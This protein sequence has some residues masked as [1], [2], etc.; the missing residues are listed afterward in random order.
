MDEERSGGAVDVKLMSLDSSDAAQQQQGSV[1][2]C[3]CAYTAL[4][5]RELRPQLRHYITARTVVTHV[6]LQ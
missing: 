5:R 2:V 1:C 3:V 4:G 6:S